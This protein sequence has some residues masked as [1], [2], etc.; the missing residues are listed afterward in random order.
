MYIICAW[1]GKQ[2]VPWNMD[3]YCVPTT[4]M[5]TAVSHLIIVKMPILRF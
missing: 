2:T 1:V 5:C 4:K 3:E